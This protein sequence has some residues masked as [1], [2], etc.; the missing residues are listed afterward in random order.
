M[1]KMWERAD[2]WP[3][4]RSPR[5]DVDDFARGV[6]RALQQTMP[7]LR[8]VLGRVTVRITLND[9]GN[10]VDVQVVRPSNLADVDQAVVFAAR[11]TSYPL[12]PPNSV[13]ADRSFVVT[14]IYK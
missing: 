6:I 7:Q 10:I 2:F 5:A 4:E 11:Q 8:E 13:P 12:P 14:Y 3:V 1:S 9:N